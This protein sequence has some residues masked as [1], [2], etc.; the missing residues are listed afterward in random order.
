MS[1]DSPLLHTLATA[2][3]S[4]GQITLVLA[5]GLGAKCGAMGL[6][7]KRDGVV[8]LDGALAL[9]EL[10]ATLVHELRHLICPDCGDD[11]IEDQTAAL[12]VPLVDALTA[13]A[14]G[15][16]AGVA[17]RLRVDEQLVRRRL[18]APDVAT[19]EAG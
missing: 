8:Y 14:T 17:A 16:Y 13:Q 12:L 5:P 10:H 3:S 19:A 11:A 2:L 6:A 15:D 18:R 1:P 9:G 4:R 7:D